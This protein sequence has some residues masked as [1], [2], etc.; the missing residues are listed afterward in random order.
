M[1]TNKR[2]KIKDGTYYHYIIL[3]VYVHSTKKWQHIIITEK[4]RTTFT[5]GNPSS[6]DPAPEP[7]PDPEPESNIDISFTDFSIYNGTN[8]PSN[9]VT[10]TVKAKN[11]GNTNVENVIGKFYISNKS[12]YENNYNTIN[13]NSQS[14]G[15]LSV[16]EE[17]T[18]SV[19][20]SLPSEGVLNSY[21]P[22]QSNLYLLGYLGSVINEKKQ[23]TIL[24][25]FLLQLF[26][27]K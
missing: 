24:K 22:N 10:A 7:E 20:I 26:T 4:N 25:L 12:T 18:F 9:T 17:R 6:P 11:I 15:N 1:N 5:I 27:K 23:K 3:Y 14:L 2:S 19:N 8:Y 13:C 21:F 16:G